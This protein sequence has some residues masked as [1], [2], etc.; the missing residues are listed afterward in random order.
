MLNDDVG[1]NEVRAVSQAQLEVLG[2]LLLLP[3]F[4][5]QDYFGQN[6][7]SA[8]KGGA[9]SPDKVYRFSK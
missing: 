5:S 9:G 6:W 4:L 8:Q 7:R 2:T 1:E 3:G